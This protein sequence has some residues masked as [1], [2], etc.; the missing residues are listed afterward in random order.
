VI[1]NN[2]IIQ[3]AKGFSIELLEVALI[4]SALS[5][6]TKASVRSL[7]LTIKQR[8]HNPKC[9]RCLLELNSTTQDSMQ[10]KSGKKAWFS[11]HVTQSN[12][13]LSGVSERAANPTQELTYTKDSSGFPSPWP[14]VTE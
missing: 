5:Q 14:I 1:R 6:M 12:G 13:T 9:N 10:V 3:K 8:N 2:A 11:F 4:S 7:K